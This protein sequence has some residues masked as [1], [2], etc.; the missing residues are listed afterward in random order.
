M[1]RSSRPPWLLLAVFFLSPALH[2]SLITTV[3][4]SPLLARLHLTL[5]PHTSRTISAQACD[6]DPYRE[7]V[8]CLYAAW[9]S[10]SLG[11]AFAPPWTSSSLGSDDTYIQPGAIAHLYLPPLLAHISRRGAELDVSTRKA[12]NQAVSVDVLL[13]WLLRSVHQHSKHLVLSCASN[14]ADLSKISPDFL[15]YLA[16][17]LP[18]LQ[19]MPRSPNAQHLGGAANSA[20]EA[21]LIASQ[22]AA[23]IGAT[24]LDP[25]R[26]RGSSAYLFL[27]DSLVVPEPEALRAAL[28]GV[29]G[30]VVTVGSLLVSA[31]EPAYD[32]WVGPSLAC[33]EPD[34]P[35]ASAIAALGACIGATLSLL[36]VPSDLSLMC[37]SAR[38]AQGKPVRYLHFG[39]SDF[40]L[41]PGLVRPAWVFQVSGFATASKLGHVLWTNITAHACLAGLHHHCTP[42]LMV[43]D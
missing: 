43:S 33:V 5:T 7:I 28:R 24:C 4:A 18:L 40:T 29:R 9:V 38:Q 25:L 1:A 27:D 21:A 32:T 16:E 10:P 20:A 15:P 11:R 42:S 2:T 39:G 8:L 23:A 22:G 30:A 17:A 34:Y 3:S 12:S 41:L 37:L 13:P 6:G 14:V 36:S 31:S 26:R 19:M 35:V